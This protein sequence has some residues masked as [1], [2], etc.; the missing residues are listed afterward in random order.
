M[1][2]C[3]LAASLKQTL[4]LFHACTQLPISALAHNGSVMG[5]SG[6]NGEAELPMAKLQP[7][8]EGNVACAELECGD[9]NSLFV[10]PICPHRGKMGLFVLGPYPKAERSGVLP[11]LLQ[12]LRSL[13][14]TCVQRQKSN[15]Y[16]RHTSRAINYIEKNYH[17]KISLQRVARHL[18]LN[19]AYLSSLFKQQTGQTF[20]EFVN[21]L[22]IEKSKELLRHSSA[23]ILDISLEVGFSNQNYFNRVFKKLTG[24]TPGEFRRQS[25]QSA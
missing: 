25:A 22:R 12:L 1:C 21:L 15:P 8:L 6:L 23:S 9:R 11:H 19:E 14:D 7:Y 20:T 18:G 3:D 17:N 16:C 10:C 24:I 13:Q 4:E 5:R 2:S